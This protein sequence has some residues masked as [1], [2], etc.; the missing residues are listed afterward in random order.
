MTDRLVAYCDGGAR[1][2]PGPAALGVSIQTPEGDE[3][4]AI[5][6]FLGEETNNVAEY[7]AVLA[8]VRR[9]AALGARG[10]RVISDS[11]LVV[12]QLNGRYKIKQPRL[13]RLAL[14]VRDAARTLDEVTYE[15]VRRAGNARADAL[16]NEALD[17]A[18]KGP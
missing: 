4:D 18:A 16:V 5:A 3:I 1:G 12:E 13:Q 6:E 17:S 8:A 9:A 14:E 15:H 10:L 11:Q 7:S 2:N